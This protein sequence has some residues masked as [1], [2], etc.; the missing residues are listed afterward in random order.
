[1]GCSCGGI[2]CIGGGS[3]MENMSPASSVLTKSDASYIRLG[4]LEIKAFKIF[5]A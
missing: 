5:V 1:M 3:W 4:T 2:S